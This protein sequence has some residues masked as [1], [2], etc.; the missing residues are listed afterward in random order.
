MSPV[1]TWLLSLCVMLYTGSAV[2]LGKG[3]KLVTLI[4]PSRNALELVASSS[5]MQMELD[6]EMS[7]LHAEIVAPFVEASNGR[8]SV[9][10]N[11]KK[12]QRMQLQL[13]RSDGRSDITSDVIATSYYELLS[14]CL[15]TEGGAWVAP[16]GLLQYVGF[17]I[18]KYV[19][20]NGKER[21]IDVEAIA[22]RMGQVLID[23][24]EGEDASPE[25][26]K[27]RALLEDPIKHGAITDC[28]ICLV[29]TAIRFAVHKELLQ[30]GSPPETF[31]FSI[32]VALP[33]NCEVGVGEVS[34]DDL[35]IILACDFGGCDDDLSLSPEVVRSWA[36]AH[37]LE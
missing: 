4:H 27:T 9:E 1:L 11:M 8:N 19:S 26:L 14:T 10:E 16:L 34:K 28:L 3:S 2:L 20:V 32:R 29:R 37:K 21:T 17:M 13:D 12:V 22:R 24:P 23:L 36:K 15:R 7:N 6:E 30:G 35:Q 18:D 31:D 5:T 33:A 25:A